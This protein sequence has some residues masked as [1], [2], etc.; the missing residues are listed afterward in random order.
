MRYIYPNSQLASKRTHP[1]ILAAAASVIVFSLT[2]AA[3]MMG[4]QPFQHAQ[5]SAADCIA[6]PAATRNHQ[7]M[8]SSDSVIP[9]ANPILELNMPSVKN[10]PAEAGPFDV[11][12][13]KA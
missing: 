7:F 9:D 6:S 5:S 4:I 13:V 10:E 8:G 11:P 2:G 1:I 12:S 3:A